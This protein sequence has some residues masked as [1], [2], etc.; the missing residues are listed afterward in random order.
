MSIPVRIIYGDEETR[1]IPAALKLAEE[2]GHVDTKLIDN[3]G[4]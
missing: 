2:Q 1:W 4:H 3:C